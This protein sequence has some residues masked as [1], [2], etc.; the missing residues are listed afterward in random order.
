MLAVDSVST[1]EQAAH[2]FYF[3]AR[4]GGGKGGRL[5]FRRECSAPWKATIGKRFASIEACC[6]ADVFL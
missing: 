1:R 3:S 6:T 2:I 4:G 5:Q